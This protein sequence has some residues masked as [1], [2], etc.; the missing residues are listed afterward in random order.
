MNVPVLWLMPHATSGF[1]VMRSWHR[2]TARPDGC[3]LCMA[4]HVVP[5]PSL[6]AAAA[7]AAAV[8]GPAAAAAA[9]ALLDLLVQRHAAQ[10]WVVLLELQALWVV[11]AVL[12]EN[13]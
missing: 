2:P 5:H 10:V 1:A 6:P 8:A 4:L 3:C 13:T 12:F 9:A 7:A 11:A